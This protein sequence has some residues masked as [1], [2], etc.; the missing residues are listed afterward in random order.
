M[1]A[2]ASPDQLTRTLAQLLR[3]P[4]GEA[5]LQELLTLAQSKGMAAADCV[6]LTDCVAAARRHLM[7]AQASAR[8]RQQH[9]AASDFGFNPIVAL[10]CPLMPLPRGDGF[11]AVAAGPRHWADVYE[12]TRPTGGGAT[13]F[14]AAQECMHIVAMLAVHTL[15]PREPPSM[16]VQPERAS[17]PSVASGQVPPPQLL[18]FVASHT[19]NAARLRLLRRSLESIRAQKGAGLAA[20][21]LSWSAEDGMKAETAIAIRDVTSAWGKQRTSDR[22]DAAADAPCEAGGTAGMGPAPLFALEQPTRRTQFEHYAILLGETRSAIRAGEGGCGAHGARCEDEGDAGPSAGGLSGGNHNEREADESAEE[23]PWLEENCGGCEVGEEEEDSLVLEDNEGPGDGESIGGMIGGC[24]IRRVCAS[25]GEG[26]DHSVNDSASEEDDGVVLE[27]NL[28][29]PGDEDG[30]P[31]EGEGGSDCGLVLEDNIEIAVLEPPGPDESSSRSATAAAGICSAGRLDAAGAR[32]LRALLATA[33]GSAC[34]VQFCDDDDILHPSR[35]EAYA[36]AI[37]A[38]P[39]SARA[40]SASWVARPIGA[41]PSLATASDVDAQVRSGRVTQTPRPGTAAGHGGGWDEYW[42]AAVRLDALSPFFDRSLPALLRSTYADLALYFYIRNSVPMA[43]FE[44]RAGFGAN[45]CYYYDK[46]TDAAAA[47]AQGSASSG[48]SAAPADVA[49]RTELRVAL[50]AALDPASPPF[51][52]PGAPLPAHASTRAVLERHAADDERLLLLAAQQ[53]SILEMFCALF[54]GAPRLPNLEAFAALGIAA[55]E[56]QLG[57]LGC[58]NAV[59]AATRASRR[60]ALVRIAAVFGLRLE[61]D[62]TPC[63]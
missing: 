27:S 33:A 57:W 29:S 10:T 41:E 49:T 61:A 26:R 6:T 4:D 40:V 1:A 38:A 13:G 14:A 28:C 56:D 17:A 30:A 63:P 21:L 52:P 3:R 37:R 15:A 16:Q 12:R 23:G 20:V 42:N 25:G 34:W 48:V 50:R 5:K 43:R 59:L 51:G 9:A 18:L 46:P 7:A 58:P 47:A 8:E 19:W 54:A 35:S 44:P 36:A 32:R 11:D 2:A 39:L 24:E 22:A 53:R 55:T 45:W 62:G 60:R 31:G